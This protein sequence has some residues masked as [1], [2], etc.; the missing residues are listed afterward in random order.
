MAAPNIELVL[1][2]E[3]GLSSSSSGDSWNDEQ[4]RPHSS[5]ILLRNAVSRICG[6]LRLDRTEVTVGERVGVYWD[7]PTVTPHG[8]DWIGMFETGW[9]E[10]WCFGGTGS[11]VKQLSS[12]GCPVTETAATLH[13]VK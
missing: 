11:Q 5:S 1:P 6:T 8:R 2:A 13:L 9:L 10:G 12:L 7:I 4:T 3:E